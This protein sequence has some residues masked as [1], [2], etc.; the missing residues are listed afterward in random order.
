MFRRFVALLT[1][2]VLC[3]TAFALTAVGTPYAPLGDQAPALTAA[4]ASTPEQVVVSD[5][6][7]AVIKGDRLSISVSADPSL[8]SVDAHLQRRITS[9]GSWGVIRTGTLDEEG[10]IR[11]EAL[12]NSYETFEFRVRV[13]SDAD[14]W[15]RIQ[16]VTVV[17]DAAA[18]A[19][20][21]DET[22][23]PS[24]I[25]NDL[26]ATVEKGSAVEITVT[27]DASHAAMKADLLRRVAPDGSW[28]V[29]RTGTL[30]ANGAA[31]FAAAPNSYKTFD[32]L[33]LIH[34][35]PAKASRVQSVTVVAAGSTPPPPAPDPDIPVDP[36][37]VV[38]DVADTLVKGNALSITV[39]TAPE[40]AGTPA[41][42][43]RRVSPDGT[44]SAIRTGTLDADGAATFEAAP[45]TYRT[46]DFRVIINTDPPRGSRVQSVTVVSRQGSPNIILITT[47]DM[48]ASDLA[49]MP[50]TRRLLKGNG[51]QNLRFISNHPLCCPARA[52]ILTGQYAQNSGVFSN[53]GTYG[54][55]QAMREPGQN[56]GAWLKQAGYTTALV[57]KHLNGWPK[58][59]V[60]QPGWTVFNPSVKR[61]YAPYGVTMY[62]N[63]NGYRT[64]WKKH[65]SDLM[66]DLTNTYIRRFTRSGAP[67]FI[68]TSQSAPHSTFRN[69]AWRPPIAPPRHRDRYKSVT[70]PAVLDPAFN[71]AD[72]SDK[73]AYVQAESK[74]SRDKA[75]RWHRE[76]IR[77]LRGVDDQVRRIVAT[78]RDVGQLS[79]T[80]I[81]FTS[82]N[83]YLLGEHR[84]WERNKP[85][86]Q[87]IDVP[88][89]VR[90]PGLPK[91]SVRTD[92]YSMVDLAPTFLDI[93]GAD[94][95]ATLDGRSMLDS[96]RVGGGGYRH[97]LIQA[98]LHEKPWWWRG[99]LT[100]DYLF[101]RYNDGF[102]ELYDRD[103]DPHQLRN[104][105]DD[106]VYSAVR[107][108]FSDRLAGLEDCVGSACITSVGG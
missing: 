10:S 75:N 40:W 49:W 72:V 61:V 45:K 90:G 87:A 44:W 82:D 57:G 71:E 77:S 50:E 26:P 28:G 34:G 84:L 94:A 89:L 29:I 69:G 41:Q 76:R 3:S 53:G 85:Y 37:V 7:P 8:A 106:P 46:F 48:R 62:N 31:A 2:V 1:A 42:L 19:G 107:D 80:Y 101:V 63:G 58:N 81:F 51:V 22:A 103:A 39:T 35:S 68:W 16:S 99:V 6:P 70:A 23:D 60:R 108:D 67:F 93:A 92:L 9:D 83:G 27:T 102:E 74:K 14:L 13:L 55:Y 17:P 21:L 91:G 11:F 15:S 86:L 104:V 97:Y 38:T 66:G 4:L 105:A 18:L 30:D 32:F 73:P 43:M 100:R 20:Y 12:P 79:N 54:G 52:E 59:P 65:T 36:S 56:I 24:V 96:L 33:V 88:L 78:L 5:L 47:D 95:G 25:V 98:G 64:Y